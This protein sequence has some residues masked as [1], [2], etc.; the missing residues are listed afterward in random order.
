MEQ[1]ML[2]KVNYKKKVASIINLKI[3]LGSYFWALNELGPLPG[4]PKRIEDYWPMKGPID[5]IV[6][7]SEGYTYIFKVSNSN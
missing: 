7:N 6:T 3:N 2:S 1:F 4:Y 5:A